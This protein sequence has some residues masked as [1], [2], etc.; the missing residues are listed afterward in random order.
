MNEISRD[1]TVELTSIRNKYSIV[2][3]TGDSD[4]RIIMHIKPDLKEVYNIPIEVVY[5]NKRELY[6]SCEDLQ[7]YG[8]LIDKDKFRQITFEKYGI[9]EYIFD[10]IKLFKG[11]RLFKAYNYK[12][13]INLRDILSY[14]K[15]KVKMPYYI[16]QIAFEDKELADYIRACAVDKKIN[17]IVL[18]YILGEMV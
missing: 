12:K 6:I 7:F 11:N 9:D 16:T 1:L 15:V 14:Y 5:V 4:E 2:G 13:E 18:E 10:Q 8:Y 17:K 3:E